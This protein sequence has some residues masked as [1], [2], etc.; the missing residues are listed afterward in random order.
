M[1]FMFDWL[2]AQKRGENNVTGVIVNY[3]DCMTRQ[4]GTISEK[5]SGSFHEPPSIADDVQKGT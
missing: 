3:D 2:T 4:G 1:I 5:M